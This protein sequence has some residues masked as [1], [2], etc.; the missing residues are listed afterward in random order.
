NE[1]GDPVDAAVVVRAERNYLYRAPASPVSGLSPRPP[2]AAGAVQIPD[3]TCFAEQ[4]PL[5]PAL[6]SDV[7]VLTVWPTTKGRGSVIA[8]IDSGI[9]ITHYD[10]RGQVHRNV[11]ECNCVAGSDD[12]GNGFVDD[13]YG[14]NAIANG[15][16]PV[17]DMQGNLKH[18]T[19]VSGIVG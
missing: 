10:L 6:G 7:H 19:H 1:F 5:S 15:G 4:W 9:D 8:V 14:Y 16:D 18:G 3:D 12:D 11:R 17:D 2:S 13:C